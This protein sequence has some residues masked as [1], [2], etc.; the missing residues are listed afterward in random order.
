[1]NTKNKYYCHVLSKTFVLLLPI[2]SQSYSSDHHS[3]E[4][5]MNI[6]R[7]QNNLFFFSTHKNQSEADHGTYQRALCRLSH[8]SQ[9]RNWKVNAGKWKKAIMHSSNIRFILLSIRLAWPKAVNVNL[10]TYQFPSARAQPNR[11]ACST[12][13]FCIKLISWNDNNKKDNDK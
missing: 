12:F 10:D 1:M 13:L 7:K 9:N 6:I 4:N 5:I 11:Q 2:S 8:S 3:V